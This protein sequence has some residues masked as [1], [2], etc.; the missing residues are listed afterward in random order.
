MPG[1]DNATIHICT[2]YIYIYVYTHMCMNTHHWLNQAFAVAEGYL[3]NPILLHCLV[4]VLIQMMIVKVRPDYC[5]LLGTRTNSDNDSKRIGDGM[6]ILG[7]PLAVT[8]VTFIVQL[9]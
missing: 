5:A 7:L 2:I 9:V 3:A 1:L 6:D 8:I 4:P